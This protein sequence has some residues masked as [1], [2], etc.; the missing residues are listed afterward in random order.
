[1]DVGDGVMASRQPK[2]TATAMARID[3]RD[4]RH[5]SEG[6][7]CARSQDACAILQ[8]VCTRLAQTFPVRLARF[9][10]R[11]YYGRLSSWGDTVCPRAMI[12][13]AATHGAWL[14]LT[15]LLR[16]NPSKDGD[17]ESRDYGDATSLGPPGRQRNDLQ[18]LRRRPFR[19]GAP[20]PRRDVKGTPGSC[21]SGSS[22]RIASR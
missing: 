17:A 12:V 8:R 10:G 1:M 11:S 14:P 5:S 9:S 2:H 22:C 21:R 20:R 19:F 7:Y 6:G 18:G 13:A 3:R 15:S 4:M 16:A